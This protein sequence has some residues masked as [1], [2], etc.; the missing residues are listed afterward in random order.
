MKF[1]VKSVDYYLTNELEKQYGEKLKKY[2]LKLI[3]DKSDTGYNYEYYT[4][5]IETIGQL[6]E[7]T[8]NVGCDIIIRSN[9]YCKYDCSEIIIYDG[10]IE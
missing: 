7:L 5:E 6:L 2:S 4:I 10:Y 9:S 1:V 3:K 8:K